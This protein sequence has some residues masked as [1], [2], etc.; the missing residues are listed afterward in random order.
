MSINLMDIAD[1]IMTKMKKHE[2]QH[3]RADQC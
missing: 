3:I 2:Y 1:D